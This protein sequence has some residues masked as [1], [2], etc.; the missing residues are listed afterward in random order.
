MMARASV[1]RGSA[2]GQLVAMSTTE[3]F[4][5]LRVSF[6]ARYVSFRSNMVL[7]QPICSTKIQAPRAHIA[8]SN[9]L[10]P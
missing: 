4:T 2:E 6:F 9:G 7:S 10:A 1:V 5:G 3:V 8:S